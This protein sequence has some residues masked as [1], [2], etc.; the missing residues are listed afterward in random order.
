MIAHVFLAAVSLCAAAERQSGDAERICYARIADLTDR[1]M[2]AQWK[3]TLATL[4]RDDLEIRREKLNLPD[5][6]PNLLASQ[7]AWLRYRDAQCGMVSDQAAGGTAGLGELDS[8][9]R[10]EL[11]RQRTI[12]LKQRAERGLLPPFP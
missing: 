3:K 8:R 7:R 1:K 4:H 12:D 11:N 6:T 10:I 9:C 2:V 5:M